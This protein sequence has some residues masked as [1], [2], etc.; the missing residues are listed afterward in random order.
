MVVMRSP[1]DPTNQEAQERRAAGHVVHRSW[2][3]HCQRARVMGQRHRRGD[4]AQDED[5]RTPRVSLDCI[6]TAA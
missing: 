2:C 3:I 5:K 1:A 6:A 4:T